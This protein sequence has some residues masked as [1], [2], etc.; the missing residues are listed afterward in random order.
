MRKMIDLIRQWRMKRLRKKIL[1]KL[2]SNPNYCPQEI[3][4]SDFIDELVCSIKK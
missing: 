1:F 4:T 3:W 2:L